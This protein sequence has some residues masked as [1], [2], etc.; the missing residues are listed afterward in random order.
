MV[1]NC[2][3]EGDFIAIL[4]GIRCPSVLRSCGDNFLFAGDLYFEGEPTGQNLAQRKPT[5]LC[6]IVLQ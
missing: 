1:P 4:D 2:A 3:V 5:E 6:D